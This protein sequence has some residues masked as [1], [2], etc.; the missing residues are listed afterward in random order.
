VNGLKAIVA[1]KAAFDNLPLEGV[2]GALVKSDLTT[3]QA[4]TKAFE[5]ALVA[6]E[7]VSVSLMI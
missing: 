1:K 4:D 5:N 7:P 6:A 2:A 3:L